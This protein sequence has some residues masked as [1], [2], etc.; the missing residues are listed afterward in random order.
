MKKIRIKRIYIFTGVL[1]AFILLFTILGFTYTKNKDISYNENIK[2]NYTIILS[3][4]R[5][6][7]NSKNSYSSEL[8]DNIKISFD[9]VR[10]F[11]S[12]ISYSNEYYLM[13]KM[14]VYDREYKNK[15]QE[16]EQTI[17]D[18]VKGNTSNGN[19]TFNKYVEIKYQDYLK[20]ANNIKRN[21]SNDSKVLLEIALY[22]LDDDN[23]KELAKVSIPLLEDNIVIDSINH[24]NNGTVVV[25]SKFNFINVFS[26]IMASICLL[27]LL[28]V[29]WKRNYKKKDNVEVI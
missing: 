13:A 24:D 25:K 16:V 10:K 14:I 21:F 19:I 9:G 7:S 22:S 18:N 20:Y 4:G 26:F 27:F 15:V 8:I 17:T 12:Y 29:F 23:S 1:L 28:F 5:E 6:F 2:S 11:N 3:N